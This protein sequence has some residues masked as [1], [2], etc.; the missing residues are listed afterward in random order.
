MTDRI[1]EVLDIVRRAS[2]LG[3]YDSNV[4]GMA[5]EI[6]V[7]DYFKMTKTTRGKKDIDGYWF[8][9]SAKR[10]VQ[11]K[12]WSE[13]RILKYR[14]GT[15]FRINEDNAPDDLIVLLIYSSKPKYDVLYNGPVAQVGKLENS[16]KYGIRRVIRFDSLKPKHEIEEILNEMKHDPIQDRGNCKSLN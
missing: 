11:V 16:S 4:I 7:E 2:L 6:I 13:S 5:A 15:F 1:S 12:A 8:S 9:D 14:A 3:D 10:T